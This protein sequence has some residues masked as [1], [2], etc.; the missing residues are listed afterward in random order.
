MSVYT[1]GRDGDVV[2][3]KDNRPEGAYFRE[4]FVEVGE[5]VKGAA[6]A[7]DVERLVMVADCC[8]VTV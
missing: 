1:C 6:D 4:E 3:G 5:V 2:L 8:W 7:R